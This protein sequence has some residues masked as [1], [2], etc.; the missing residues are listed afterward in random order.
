MFAE[1]VGINY[2]RHKLCDWGI[3]YGHWYNE[4]VAIKDFMKQVLSSENTRN[5]EHL[6]PKGV[7]E[8]LAAHLSGRKNYTQTL[9]RLM[10]YAVWSKNSL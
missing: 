2:D 6:N 10:T 8:I 7:G 3:D 4:S 5:C 1:K 9:N